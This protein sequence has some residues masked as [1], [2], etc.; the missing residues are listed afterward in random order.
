MP[1]SSRFWWVWILAGV[2]ACWF[3]LIFEYALVHSGDTS[4][5]TNSGADVPAPVAAPSD[6]EHSGQLTLDDLRRE[7]RAEFPP[8][9]APIPKP[10]PSVSQ[11][12]LDWLESSWGLMI[13]GLCSSGAAT[14]CCFLVGVIRLVKWAWSD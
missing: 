11:R 4:T 14:V 1:R 8:Q 3:F 7:A 9:T 12:A 10:P 13:F 6:R 5:S 2:A